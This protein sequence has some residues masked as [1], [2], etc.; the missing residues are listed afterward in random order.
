M[1]EIGLAGLAVPLATRLI[2]ALHFRPS[3]I[4]CVLLLSFA[5]ISWCLLGIKVT[6]D[7]ANND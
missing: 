5:L 1:R 3:N 7:T 2:C 4:A 6:A